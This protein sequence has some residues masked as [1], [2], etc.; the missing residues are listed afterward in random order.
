MVLDLVKNSRRLA[1]FRIFPIWSSRWGPL[2]AWISNNGL[3]EWQEDKDG[4]LLPVTFDLSTG[5][6]TPM[7]SA[8]DTLTALSARNSG[9]IYGSVAA[10]DGK[11]ILCA[12]CVRRQGLVD[13]ALLSTVGGVNSVAPVVSAGGRVPIG[14]ISIPYPGYLPAAWNTQSTAW[15]TLQGGSDGQKCLV[16]FSAGTDGAPTVL[17]LP[18]F[19]IPEGPL[20]D[21]C[22]INVDSRGMGLAVGSPNVPVGHVYLIEIPTGATKKHSLVR[23]TVLI[24]SSVIVRAVW[25]S[26]NGTRIAWTLEFRKESGDDQTE[27][28]T[29]LWICDR[30]GRN[31]RAVASHTSRNG[32]PKSGIDYPSEFIWRP[33]GKAVS[34]VYLNALWLFRVPNAGR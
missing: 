24:P 34:F 3:L 21:V 18:D 2:Y 4:R 27:L 16:C 19:E 13:W 30:S 12:S 26:P 15:Y 20:T 5:M 8:A 31:M 11:S 29:E 22:L 28:R 23:H 32:A 6:Y 25:A 10:P 17:P 33:D 14:R 7:Q 9:S 1:D